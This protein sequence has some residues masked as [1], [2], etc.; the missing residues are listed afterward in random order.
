MAR[1]ALILILLALAF[2]WYAV[3]DNRRYHL[4]AAR[5]EVRRLRKEQEGQRVD[6]EIGRQQRER[7]SSYRQWELDNYMAMNAADKAEYLNT[8]RKAGIDPTEFGIEV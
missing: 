4:K 2:H 5:V 3:A 7:A 1:N 6:A 8:L